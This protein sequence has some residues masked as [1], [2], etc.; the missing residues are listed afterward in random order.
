MSADKRLK[1][2]E[3]HALIGATMTAHSNLSCGFL[4]AV[5]Q[6]ALEIELINAKSHL[7]EK[8]HYQYIIQINC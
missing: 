7:K 1:D 4:E 8:L 3:T 2:Q 5:Y 6:E